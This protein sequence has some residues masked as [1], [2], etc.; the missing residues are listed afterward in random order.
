MELSTHPQLAH[1]TT[2]QS[3]VMQSAAHRLLNR[4]ISDFLFAYDLT[5]MQWFIIG[6]IYDH[7]DAGL[8]LT[9]LT[10]QLDTTLPYTTTTITLLEFKGIV[11]K[12]AHKEDNRT[13]LV[14]IAPEYRATVE[15]IESGLRDRL[16][17]H[18]YQNDHISREEL[19]TYLTVLHKIANSSKQP[20]TRKTP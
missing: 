14:S 9:D 17:Q 7:G 16:R 18:L 19:Q 2:Y 12:R 11:I 4:I 5:A 8:R 6:H 13:K 20:G 3:G 1:I 10:K 15:E